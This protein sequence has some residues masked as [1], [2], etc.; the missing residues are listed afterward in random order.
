MSGTMKLKEV[1]DVVVVGGGLTGYTAGILL[2]KNGLRA[3]VVEGFPWEWWLEAESASPTF[4]N[5]SGGLL[6]GVPGYQPLTSLLVKLGFPLTTPSGHGPVLLKTVEPALQVIM[7]RHRINLYPGRD[8][9]LR[10]LQREFSK[11]GDLFPKLY[12]QAWLQQEAVRT[13]YLRRRSV[14]PRKK[15]DPSPVFNRLSALWSAWFKGQN[16]PAHRLL[17]GMGAGGEAMDFLELLLFAVARRRLGEMNAEE[18]YHYLK[19]AA[20]PACL[21]DMGQVGIY[22]GLKSLFRRH[23]GVV[24]QAGSRLDANVQKKGEVT[25]R[26]GS[27][28]HLNGRWIVVDVPEGETEKLLGRK[29]LPGKIQEHV[30][31]AAHLTFLV[32]KETIPVGM[33]RQLVIGDRLGGKPLILTLSPGEGERLSLEA[34]APLPGKTPVN[35]TEVLTNDVLGKIREVVRFLP[36]DIPPPEVRFGFSPSGHGRHSLLK[37]IQGPDLMGESIG[38][39]RYGSFLVVGQ[40][41]YIGSPLNDVLMLGQK[42]AAWIVNRGRI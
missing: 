23:G 6:Y 5:F 1:F 20:E 32:P 39:S 8:E 36:E 17:T 18:V 3:A 14:R 13:S 28:H 22:W 31:P 21:N 16:Q 7:P 29:I 34:L 15:M 2:V 11:C 38:W 27:Q 26:V 9:Q 41:D 30:R 12:E 19:L 37:G 42:M 10:E 4:F 40:G 35:D 24:Y 33:G 25:L